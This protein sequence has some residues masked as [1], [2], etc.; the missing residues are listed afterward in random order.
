[1]DLTT[2]EPNATDAYIDT[3]PVIDLSINTT[4]TEGTI[5][6]PVL[7]SYSYYNRAYKSYVTHDYALTKDQR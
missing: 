6:S 5:T 4:T 3:L 7:L 2:I 1:M